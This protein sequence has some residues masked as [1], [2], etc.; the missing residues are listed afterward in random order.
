LALPPPF[1]AARRGFGVQ[2]RPVMTAA[3]PMTALRIEE[4]PALM[5]DGIAEF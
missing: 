2:V 1:A 5:S 4:R 3:A